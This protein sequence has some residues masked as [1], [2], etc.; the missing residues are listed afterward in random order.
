[1]EKRDEC[2]GVAEGC[3]CAMSACGRRE[4]AMYRIVNDCTLLGH[5]AERHVPN[6]AITAS[7]IAGNPDL[8]YFNNSKFVIH[9]TPGGVS[10]PMSSP[11]FFIYLCLHEFF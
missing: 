10:F 4:G 8:I 11:F 3:L 9:L 2:G 6:T 5:D 1:M 7:K